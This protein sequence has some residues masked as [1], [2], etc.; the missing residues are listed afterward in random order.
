MS[1]AQLRD[2]NKYLGLN[3]QGPVVQSINATMNG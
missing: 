1:E 2:L 3:I